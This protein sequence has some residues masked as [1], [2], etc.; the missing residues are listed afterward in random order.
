MPS[1]DAFTILQLPT[2]QQMS[3]IQTKVF[4]YGALPVYFQ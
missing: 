2:L 3:H 1:V 4:E